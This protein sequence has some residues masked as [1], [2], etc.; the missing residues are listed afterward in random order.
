VKAKPKP[1]RKK[2][3]KCEINL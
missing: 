3:K 2:P 1:D